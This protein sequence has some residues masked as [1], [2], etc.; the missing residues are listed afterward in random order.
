VGAVRF[1]TPGY[2]RDPFCFH[3]DD[4]KAAAVLIECLQPLADK[5][6]KPRR[7]STLGDSEKDAVWGQI[8]GNNKVGGSRYM[9]TPVGWL[10]KFSG[11]SQW[12]PWDGNCISNPFHVD[13]GFEEILT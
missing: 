12:F 1:N 3:I 2:A 7:V 11:E 13:R 9:W 5:A 10:R 8:L 4:P 6:P